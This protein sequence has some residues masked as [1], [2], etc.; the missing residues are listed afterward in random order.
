MRRARTLLT[1]ALVLSLPLSAG[2][3]ATALAHPP[4]VAPVAVPQVQVQKASLGPL[5]PP[6]PAR[7]GKVSSSVVS[8]SGKP[9]RVRELAWKRSASSKSFVM[10]DGTTQTVLSADPVH[11]RDGKGKWQDID[12][13]VTAATGE[14]AFENAKNGF[15]S[16]FGKSSDRLISFEADGASIR[17]GAAGDTSGS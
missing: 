6:V 7:L 8:S 15:R 12:T 16:R 10:S 11:Y 1:S 4:Q 5:A 3:P 9:A 14:D 13:K 17:L 2:V